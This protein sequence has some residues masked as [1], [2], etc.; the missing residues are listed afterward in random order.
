MYSYIIHIYIHKC[1][2]IC[3]YIC[4]IYI[5]ICIYMCIIH[6]YTKRKISDILLVLRIIILNELL[7]VKPAKYR[8]FYV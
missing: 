3:I 5:Y 8:W 4:I 7:Y 6:V 1:I 2:C